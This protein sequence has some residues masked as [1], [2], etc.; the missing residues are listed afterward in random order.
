MTTRLISLI[1]SLLTLLT[2]YSQ[3]DTQPG[4]VKKI[5]D[6][7]K[8]PHI[9]NEDLKKIDTSFWN[10]PHE[11][12]LLQFDKPQIYYLDTLNNGIVR[13]YLTHGRL[14]RHFEESVPA[15]NLYFKKN[16]II[17]LKEVYINSSR[18]GSCGRLTITNSL[19]FKAGELV[20]CAKNEEPFICYNIPVE[21]EKL[22]LFAKYLQANIKTLDFAIYIHTLTNYKN[23]L[24]QSKSGANQIKTQNRANIDASVT[25][26]LNLED[27]QLMWVKQTFGLPIKGNQINKKWISWPVLFSSITSIGD[28]YLIVE[29]PDLTRQNTAIYHSSTYY[30]T[31]KK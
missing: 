31:R 12:Q 9:D 18:M 29:V 3:N 24:L 13:L 14:G 30:F 25:A 27:Y 8:A 15:Y 20:Y 16:K 2:A 11:L 7:I 5:E 26:N 6:Q 28:T 17:A 23:N 22:R 10:F 1:L 21:K 19:Y 4:W